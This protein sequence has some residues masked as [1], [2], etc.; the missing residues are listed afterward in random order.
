MGGDRGLRGYPTIILQ[1]VIS[2]IYSQDHNVERC[3]KNG[4]ILIGCGV[5]AQDNYIQFIKKYKYN[6]KLIVDTIEAKQSVVES[7]KNIFKKS[8]D[9]YFVKALKH[10][11]KIRKEDYDWLTNYA[12]HNDVGSVIISTDPLTHRMYLEWAIDAGLNILCEKPLTG[13]A[14]IS[15]NVTLARKL[16]SDFEN[17]SEACEHKNLK[18][19]IQTQRRYHPVYEFVYSAVKKVVLDYGITINYIGIFSGNGI[20]NSV[21]EYVTK[22]NHPHNKGYGKLLHSGYHFVDLFSWFAELNTLINGVRYTEVSVFT[23]IYS[24]KDLNSQFERVHGKHKLLSSD[25][26]FKS[27][28]ENEIKKLDGLGE[29]DLYSQI[30][31][32]S[33]EVTILNGHLA[34]LQNSASKRSTIDYNVGDFKNSSAIR[35]ELFVIEIGPMYSICAFALQNHSVNPLKS[36]DYSH[37]VTIHRNSKYMKGKA[38]EEVYFRNSSGG[39]KINSFSKKARLR[40]FQDFLDS[41]NKSD[42]KSHRLSIG[43]FALIQENVARI[44]SHKLGFSKKII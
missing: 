23:N 31:L 22:E 7:I 32:R 35:K 41:K 33:G 28:G 20:F 18:L 16:N 19:N 5:H 6:L 13:Y 44:N 29:V 42:L 39:E 21:Q 2:M 40:C 4:L 38:Y 24:V 11:S 1:I 9:L 27:Q 17:L 8:P 25:P 26:L 14:G 15:N 43:I 37:V 12:K 34:L 30:M 10:A 36:H 3:M